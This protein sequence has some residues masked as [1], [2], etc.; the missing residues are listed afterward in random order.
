MSEIIKAKHYYCSKFGDLDMMLCPKSPNNDDDWDELEDP[1]SD[2]GWRTYTEI[3]MHTF[4][5]KCIKD[6]YKAKIGDEVDAYVNGSGMLVVN[7]YITSMD[8]FKEY[9]KI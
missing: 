7:G 2:C 6:R 3:E 1:C 9:F 5:V 4:K 8:E